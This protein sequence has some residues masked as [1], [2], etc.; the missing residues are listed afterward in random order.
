MSEALGVLGEVVPL[1]LRAAAAVAFTLVGMFVELNALASILSGE[2]A[3][4]LWALYMGA[5]ALYAGL[6]VFG[7]DVLARVVP[8]SA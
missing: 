7:A 3:F 5:I 8:R 4:G 6:F 1:A 2:F